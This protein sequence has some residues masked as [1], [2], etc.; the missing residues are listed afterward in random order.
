[1][2]IAAYL[3]MQMCFMDPC[4]YNGTNPVMSAKY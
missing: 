3:S 1:M 4:T 2:D